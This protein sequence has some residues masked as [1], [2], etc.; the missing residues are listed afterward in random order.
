LQ[1]DVGTL[2]YD[3]EFVFLKTD[4]DVK[5]AVRELARGYMYEGGL[6]V[7]EVAETMA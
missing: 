3:G 5:V 7:G 2:E 4:P 6:T 1:A